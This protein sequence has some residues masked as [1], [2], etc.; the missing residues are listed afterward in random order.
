FRYEPGKTVKKLVEEWPVSACQ[1]EAE[2]EK[3]LASFLKTKFGKTPKVRRQ[4]GA[5]S[6]RCDIQVGKE[7]A[8]EL[9]TN[10]DS[11]S[12]L[13]RLIGQIEL[14][15]KESSAELVIVLIGQSRDDLEDT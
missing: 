7:V 5:G 2:Y 1:T 14:Y 10:L 15:K 4:Q 8:L 6:T 11:T 12:K 3:Q 13:Q 9:K